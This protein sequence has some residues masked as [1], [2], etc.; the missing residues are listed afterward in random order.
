MKTMLGIALLFTIIKSVFSLLVQIATIP[1][2]NSFNFLIGNEYIRKG[3]GALVLI[4]GI[5]DLTVSLP[6]DLSVMKLIYIYMVA[7]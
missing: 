4:Y 7:L 2:G 6:Q 5:M 3:T 1:T